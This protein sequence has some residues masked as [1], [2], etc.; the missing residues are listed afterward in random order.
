MSG[1]SATVGQQAETQKFWIFLGL[2]VSG[3]LLFGLLR[4]GGR[5]AHGRR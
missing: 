3:I 4:K 2:T 1:L 5:L